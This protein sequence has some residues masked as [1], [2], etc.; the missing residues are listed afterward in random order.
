MQKFSIKLFSRYSDLWRFIQLF[1]NLSIKLI[2]DE[3]NKSIESYNL[4]LRSFLCT[5]VCSFVTK[6]TI[7]EMDMREKSLNH[8]CQEVVQVY[9]SLGKKISKCLPLGKASCD[10]KRNY[11]IKVFIPNIKPKYLVFR[12]NLL[13]MYFQSNKISPTNICI[14]YRHVQILHNFCIRPGQK[15]CYAAYRACIGK[16]KFNIVDFKIFHNDGSWAFFMT[17]YN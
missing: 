14:N 6:N 11:E 5:P 13:M 7:R 16:L 10:K 9:L 15:K 17:F 1:N 12:E 3:P 4:K 2:F 8:K